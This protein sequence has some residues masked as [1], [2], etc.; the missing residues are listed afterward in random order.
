MLSL[1]ALTHPTLMPTDPLCTLATS[2]FGS[3]PQEQSKQLTGPLFSLTGEDQ[4]GHGVPSDSSEIPWKSPDTNMPVGMMLGIQRGFQL[5]HL[6]V[7]S[8]RDPDGHL[9]VSDADGDG[10]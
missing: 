9:M 10:S 4:R 7:L 2:G 5:S 1:H 8:V 6:P 3:S